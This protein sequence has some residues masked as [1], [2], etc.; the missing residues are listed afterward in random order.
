MPALGSEVSGERGPLELPVML[1][2][3]RGQNDLVAKTEASPQQDG[4]EVPHTSMNSHALPRGRDHPDSGPSTL[5]RNLQCMGVCVA[6]LVLGRETWT[7]LWSR[8]NQAIPKVLGQQA[9][10]C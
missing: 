5:F 9:P 10:Q 1:M 6:W 7:V 8:G 4:T 2:T 3:S